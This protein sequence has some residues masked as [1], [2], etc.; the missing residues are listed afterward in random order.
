MLIVG[1]VLTAGAAGGTVAVLSS[2]NT[3]STEATTTTTATN[4]TTTESGPSN[5]VPGPIEERVTNVEQEVTQVKKR[6]D[7]IEQVATTTTSLPYTTPTIPP[8]D[9][10]KPPATLTL[11]VQP[12]GSIQVTWQPVEGA[13][14]YG[15]ELHTYGPSWSESCCAATVAYGRAPAGAHLEVWAV[16]ARGNRGP[17]TTVRLPDSKPACDPSFFDT[18][19]ARFTV[20]AA[21]STVTVITVFVEPTAP[22]VMDGYKVRI[23]GIA[24]TTNDGD[25]P[26]QYEGISMPVSAH[27]SYSYRIDLVNASDNGPRPPLEVGFVEITRLTC[28]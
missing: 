16:D 18:K 24:H 26:F 27:S 9:V 5:T 4:T 19:S 11:A 23:A 12:Q 6:V 17:G 2:S 20:D 10:I 1:F 8:A 13:D 21:Y 7:A 22:R 14:R 25:H 28:V 3:S 15:V